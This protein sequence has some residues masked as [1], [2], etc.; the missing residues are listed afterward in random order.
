LIFGRRSSPSREKAS[1]TIC[2]EFELAIQQGVVPL[3][4][5]QS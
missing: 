3:M 5:D 4:L 1:V 2:K